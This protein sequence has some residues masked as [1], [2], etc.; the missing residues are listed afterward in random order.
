MKEKYIFYEHAGKY[1][2]HLDQI[3]DLLEEKGFRT[4]ID[5]HHIVRK[6]NLK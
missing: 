5:A 1:P 2:Y 4:K 6:D 3:G